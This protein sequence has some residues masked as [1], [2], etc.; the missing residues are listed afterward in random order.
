MRVRVELDPNRHEHRR[1]LGPLLELL[2]RLPRH[3]CPSYG[4]GED[5]VA[6]QSGAEEALAAAD[7]E[8]QHLHRRR[9]RIDDR[10]RCR[11]WCRCRACPLIAPR[12]R[13]H[14]IRR[15]ST[16]RQIGRKLAIRRMLVQ[17]IRHE[18]V[19]A[20]HLRIVDRAPI[21]LAE[22]RRRRRNDRLL[23]YRLERR[24]GRRDRARERLHQRR[25][26][27]P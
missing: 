12:Q 2:F 1:Q 3:P 9:C 20:L 16:D 13:P 14:P 11:W 6:G 7:L 19:L 26:A 5:G 27:E 24:C 22:H 10:R 25:R 4:L 18:L 23:E 21:P 15:P 8:L 17:R